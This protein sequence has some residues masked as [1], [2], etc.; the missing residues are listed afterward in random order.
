MKSSASE[1]QPFPKTFH[2]RQPNEPPIMGVLI[3]LT[4]LNM[5]C[6][7]AFSCTAEK[8]NTRTIIPINLFHFFV[9]FFKPNRRHLRRDHCQ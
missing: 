1:S 2:S 3:V 8:H 9:V 6:N 4:K 7:C 5:H